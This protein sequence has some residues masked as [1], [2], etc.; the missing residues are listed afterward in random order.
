M[1]DP[2]AGDRL[3]NSW[4]TSV[5]HLRWRELLDAHDELP[6]G[7]VEEFQSQLGAAA[8][9]RIRKRGTR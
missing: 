8:G 5:G 3:R 6:A 7:G 2:S 9:Q 1:T 4:V